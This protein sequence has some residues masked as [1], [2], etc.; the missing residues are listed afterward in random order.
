M[1]LKR[2]VVALIVVLAGC[3]ATPAFGF[4]FRQVPGSPLTAVADWMA[5]SPNGRL[6][7]TSAQE[8]MQVVLI[9]PHTGAA[10]MGPTP[11]IVSAALAPGPYPCAFSPDGHLL[12]CSVSMEG[13]VT[14]SVNPTTGHLRELSLHSGTDTEWVAFSPN[15]KFVLQGYNG[16]SVYRINHVTGALNEIRGSP[17]RTRD[18][19]PSGVAFSPKGNLL[20]ATL[21]QGVSLFAI[22]NRTGSLKEV[23][24]AFHLVA[25]PGGDPGNVTVDPLFSPQGRFLFVPDQAAAEVAV[26]LV[27]ETTGALADAAGSPCATAGAISSAVLSPDGR[28][29]ATTPMNPDPTVS[30]FS[31]DEQTGMLRPEPGSPIRVA[32]E[33]DGVAFSPRGGLLAV[34]DAIDQLLWIYRLPTCSDPDQDGDCDQA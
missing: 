21:G 34:S 17:F 3:F 23:S 12:V 14:F 9:N 2:T 1:K 27:N 24:H 18:Y 5:F 26:L 7:L 19:D 20:A 16:I 4:A 32:G 22:S 25:N 8:F 29:L 28:L 33:A 15:G 13:L 30:L 6:L 31:V 10:R 11:L